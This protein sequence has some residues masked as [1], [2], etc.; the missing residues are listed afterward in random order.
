MMGTNLREIEE[1]KKKEW[2]ME[3]KPGNRKT[4]EE[5]DDYNKPDDRG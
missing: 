2:F 4:S 3:G 1:K 5:T